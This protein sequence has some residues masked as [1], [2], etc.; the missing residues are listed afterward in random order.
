MEKSCLKEKF[1]EKGLES[2]IKENGDNLSAGERQLI[3]IAQAILKKNKIV[4]IDEATANLD[5]STDREI[6]RVIKDNFAESTV[7]TIAHRIDTIMSSDRVIVL[8]AGQVVEVGEP[9]R[10]IK[11]K[12][13]KFQGL[14]QEARTGMSKN[15]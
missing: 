14:W 13:S 6:Q 15:L 1:K 12:N 10:L 5:I 7:L 3:C 2:E 9:Y 4:L 11:K 8:H